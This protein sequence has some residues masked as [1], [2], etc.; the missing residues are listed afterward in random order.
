MSA[1]FRFTV[2]GKYEI[3]GRHEPQITANV[4]SGSG[5]AFVHAGTLTM[6]Q[7]EWA[8]LIDALLKSLPGDVEIEDARHLIIDPVISE[9][10]DKVT[11][12]A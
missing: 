1:R 12:P 6:S 9:D 7:S 8:S 11:R 5:T 2:I 4:A 3:A 10:A